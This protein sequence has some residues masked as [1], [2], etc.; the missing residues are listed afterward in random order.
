MTSFEEGRY[1]VRIVEQGFTVSSQKQT[2]G[3]VLYFRVL[4]NL[5]QPNAPVKPYQRDLTM[6]LNNDS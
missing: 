4:K 6:W 5:D 3:F 1:Q 2:P